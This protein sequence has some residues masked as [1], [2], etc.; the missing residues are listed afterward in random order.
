VAEEVIR[1]ENEIYYRYVERVA[2][3]IADSEFKFFAE[4]VSNANTAIP[5]ARFLERELGWLIHDV[6]ITDVLTQSQKHTLAD[7]F[8]ALGLRG[9][10]IFE[11]DTWKI[12]QAITRNHPDYHGELYFNADG[13]LF[14]LGSSFEKEFA[15]KRAASLLGVSYPLYHRA[16]LDRGYAGY[17]GGLHLLEDILSVL[18]AGK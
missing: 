11:T 1:S 7:R 17:R 14:V 6:V 5:Y 12:E 3:V 18:V 2:D 16:V 4:V 13:P 8:E 9:N 15:A 10:L